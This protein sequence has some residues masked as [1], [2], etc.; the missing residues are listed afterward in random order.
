V[1]HA[2]LFGLGTIDP[3]INAVWT[4]SQTFATFALVWLAWRLLRQPASAAH[5]AALAVPVTV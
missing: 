2:V 4:T 5:P 1:M 3:R